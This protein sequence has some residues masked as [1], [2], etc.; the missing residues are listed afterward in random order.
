MIRNP[1]FNKFRVYGPDPFPAFSLPPPQQGL[2]GSITGSL[3]TTGTYMP[4]GMPTGTH[5]PPGMP[6]GTYIPHGPAYGPEH[7]PNLSAPSLTPTTS[8]TPTT[9][10]PSIYQDYYWGQMLGPTH[11]PFNVPPGIYGGFNW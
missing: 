5:M 8:T 6:T 1:F 4:Y 2:S 9:F 10:I 7:V 11:H 3:P